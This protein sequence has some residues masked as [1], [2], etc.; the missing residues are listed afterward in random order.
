MNVSQKRYSAYLKSAA[1]HWGNDNR[2]ALQNNKSKI[3]ELY[4]SVRALNLSTVE[5][6]LT[7]EKIDVNLLSYG[8]ANTC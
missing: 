3:L 5:H 2:K 6:N 7:I 4:R 8:L 1:Y